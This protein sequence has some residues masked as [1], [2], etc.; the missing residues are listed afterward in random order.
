[1]LKNEEC[2][3]D[4]SAMKCLIGQREEV[5][6]AL[7]YGVSPIKETGKSMEVLHCCRCQSRK[8]TPTSVL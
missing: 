1:M 2:M 8:T 5:M 7:E 4:D 3:G 6:G